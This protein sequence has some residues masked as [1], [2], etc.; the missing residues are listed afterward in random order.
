MAPTV[1]GGSAHPERHRDSRVGPVSQAGWE[2]PPGLR[3]RSPGTVREW[4]G[5]FTHVPD[6]HWNATSP[7]AITPRPRDAPPSSAKAPALCG[8][9][10]RPL[11]TYAV[12]DIPSPTDPPQLLLS[13]HVA[14]TDVLLHTQ[15][16]HHAR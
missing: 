11:P 10:P 12:E 8:A 14:L 2:L 9:M 4:A 3:Q 13:A 1:Q 6:M 16:E 15:H 5:H 7:H